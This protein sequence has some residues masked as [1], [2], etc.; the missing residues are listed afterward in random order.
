MHEFYQQLDPPDIETYSPYPFPPDES[1]LDF[2]VALYKG[3]SILRY[4]GDA[5][6]YMPAA[7][8]ESV[9]EHTLHV[10]Y[11]SFVLLYENP[12]LLALLDEQELTRF[13]L[14][15]DLGEMGLN[16]R[17]WTI[18]DVVNGTVDT[19]NKHEE[20]R[21]F[22][23]EIT[24]PLAPAVRNSIRYYHEE[25]ENAPQ[26]GNINALLARYMDATQGILTAFSHADTSHEEY[27]KASI[28]T[29]RKKLMPTFDAIKQSLETRLSAGEDVEGAIAEIEALHDYILTFFPNAVE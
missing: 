4:R 3:N 25:Y 20:E 21:R 11:V 29:R 10:Q 14:F 26:T 9:A 19:H 28:Y 16:G 7:F 13:I 12:R 24:R 2:L 18:T 27:H 15:H 22:V 17:D 6:E 8:R 23:E 5:A 1:S